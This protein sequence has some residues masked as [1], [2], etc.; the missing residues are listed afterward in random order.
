MKS[1]EREQ[2]I[3]EEGRKEGRELQLEAYKHLILQLNKEQRLDDI[4]KAASDP[5][6][7]SELYQE[8]GIK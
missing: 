7:L 3:R 2:F 5:E 1:W 8:Y 4:V 6:Y